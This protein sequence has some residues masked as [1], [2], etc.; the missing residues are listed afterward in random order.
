MASQKQILYVK[1]LVG[2]HNLVLTMDPAEMT[3]K[4]AAGIPACLQ[5]A[6][7]NKPFEND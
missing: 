2:K 1:D 6:A 4:Q 7:C 5:H 3:M